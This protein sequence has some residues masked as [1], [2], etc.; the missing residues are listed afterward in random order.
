MTA[1]VVIVGAGPA[2]ASAAL[3]LAKAGVAS[4]LLDDNPRAGGQIFR[5]G[6]D[7]G[8]PR[9]G[10]DPRGD[11][12]REGLRRYGSLIDHRSGH[13]VIA[14]YPD[15]RLWVAGPERAY[16][17]E[18]EHL[19]LAT[20]A[21]EVSVP[22]P[23]WTLP[24]VYTLGGLQILAKA[25]ASV[26]AG[27]TVLAGAGPLL[28]L[29]A[30]Q[31]AEAGVD[32]RAVIDAAPLPTLGQLAGMAMAPALL[33]RGIGFEVILRRHGI[34]LLR[35]HAVTALEGDGRVRSL[36]VVPVDEDWAPR[37]ERGGTLEADAV[38]MSF[39][40]RSNTE[41]TQLAGCEH[42]YDAPS[43]G[44]RVARDAG[45]ATSAENVYVVGDGAGIGG[46]DTALAEGTILGCDLARRLG[47][48]NTVLDNEAKEAGQRLGP[49]S[50]FRR[51]LVDWSGLRPGIFR[52]ANAS[53]IVCR[54]EDVTAGN[55]DAALDR[56]LT[57]PRGL[58]LGT[59][60]GMG[61]CQGRTCH[62][63]VQERLARHS[64]ASLADQPMPTVRVPLRPVSAAMLASL[65]PT[66]PG[67]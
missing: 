9:I 46:V 41:L 23:G 8:P 36:R 12:L 30:A 58:K 2:G 28:Y 5:A 53:T 38:G 66:L 20:G 55:I 16:E 19:V 57:L 29:V 10:G 40:L 15:R 50:S 60:A 4:L 21:I 7:G 31:L 33:A 48:S 24:G 18:S 32:V 65:A 27:K 1:Q 64:G 37:P 22:V 3:A 63:A 42:A 43:G 39:G 13:E 44:W 26:P 6:F 49:L 11:T 34:R 54:C 61:L 47:V 14:I 52:I 67:E 45:Y 59:R 25:S 62:P 56:G 17:L 35:G 51:A